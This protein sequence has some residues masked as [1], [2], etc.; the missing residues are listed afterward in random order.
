MSAF[1]P[2][3]LSMTQKMK[4]TLEETA[5]LVKWIAPIIFGILILWLNSRY[6]TVEAYNILEN[7]VETI[8]FSNSKNEA[9]LNK[10]VEIINTKLEYILTDVKEIKAKV[11]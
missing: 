6:S 1:V 11:K 4:E 10:K 7:K 3:R 9:D 2:K 8:E 5:S